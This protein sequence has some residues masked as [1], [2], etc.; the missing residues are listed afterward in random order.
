MSLTLYGLKNCDSCKKAIKAL[1]GA[2]IAV[3]FHD[4]R[5]DGASM[6]QLEQ[7]L[8]AVGRDKLM[9]TRSTT[10][11]GLSDEERQIN[12]DADAKRLLSLHP[13]LIKRPVIETKET[14]SV[15]WAKGREAE[16]L[17]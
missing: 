2:G 6:A 1:E 7:W 16:F 10:W 9:N 8:G 15:G 14:I 13:T 12:I 5:S 3:T 17:S 11:R 4:V